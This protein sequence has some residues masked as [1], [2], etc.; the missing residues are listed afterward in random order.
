MLSVVVVSHGR[1]QALARCLTGLWK[2]EATGV[3]IIV[4]A[5]PEGLAAA[6]ALP[7]HNSL[8]T[9]EQ[10]LPHIS[11]ARNDGLVRAAGDIVAFIDDDA[12][13]EPSW[14]KAIQTAFAQD[15][16]CSALTGPVLGRNGIST[17]WGSL[18]IDA[19]GADHPMPELDTGQPMLARKLRGTNMV[20][21]G[22]CCCP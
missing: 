14:A 18:G 13:P 7:F 6:R 12:V 20:C 9:A 22:I 17:Q 19:V 11:A 2:M 10:S 5:D 15:P 21:A 3:E 4:V 8:K 1:A 16:N